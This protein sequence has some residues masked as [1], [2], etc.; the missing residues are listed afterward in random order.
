VNL[1]GAS[2]RATLF[3]K[4]A[5]SLSIDAASQ[6]LAMQKEQEDRSRMST[7]I[8]CSCSV[9]TIPAIDTNVIEALDLPRDATR[10][11]LYQ[12]GCAAGVVGLSLAQKLCRPGHDALII[13]SE[14]CSLVFHRNDF[15]G[16]SIIGSVLFGDGAACAWISDSG[17]GLEFIDTQSY[18]IP[19]S[20][21]QMGYDIFDEGSYLRLSSELPQVLARNMPDLVN[22]FLDRNRL[23]AKNVK[24][25]LFH[26]GGIKLLQ[27]FEQTFELQRKQTRWSWQV[28][29]RFGNM[30]SATIL[31]VLSKFM[32]EQDFSAGDNILVA[33]VGPGLTVELVL[34]RA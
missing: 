27:I 22:A 1:G 4:H 29:S 26:P 21:D 28:L 23:S 7:I 34:L 11:P 24:S 12:Q 20:Q 6:I 2:Q 3:H 15:S 31:F 19:D 17:P 5:T 8:S 25:W 14:L 32:E 33:G 10:V 30:S 9:P 13:S 16:A 18:L